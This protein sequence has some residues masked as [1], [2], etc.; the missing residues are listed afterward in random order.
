MCRKSCRGDGGRGKEGEKKKPLR[1]FTIVAVNMK[2]LLLKGKRGVS[3]S[4][5]FVFMVP[6]LSA[7][8]R[9]EEIQ[10]ALVMVLR[11]VPL[12]ELS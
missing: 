12:F 6:E 5:P 9:K 4:S 3:M 2:G 8:W 11:L 10:A 1:A 7:C